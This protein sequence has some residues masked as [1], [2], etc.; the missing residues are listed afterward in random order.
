MAD[1][2]EDWWFNQAWWDAW[3]TQDREREIKER[4]PGDNKIYFGKHKGKTISEVYEIDLKYLDWMIGN[5][6]EANKTRRMVIAYLEEL[7]R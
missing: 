4:K 7:N 1:S 3:E 2:S 6:E 5:F